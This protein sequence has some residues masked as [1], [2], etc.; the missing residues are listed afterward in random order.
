[1]TS[2]PVIITGADQFS[3]IRELAKQTPVNR[4]E[5]PS[6]DLLDLNTTILVTKTCTTTTKQIPIRLNNQSL[7]VTCIG[8]ARCT[9]VNGHRPISAHLPTQQWH[10]CTDD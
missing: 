7:M 10:R 6:I 9:L 5:L 3:I 2:Y 1:M 8:L 4:D